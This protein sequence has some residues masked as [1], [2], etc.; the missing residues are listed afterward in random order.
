MGDVLLALLLDELVGDVRE[1]L[2]NLKLLERVV[3]FQP[4][5]LVIV[6]VPVGC[7]CSHGDGNRNP[8][9]SA[10]NSASE[11]TYQ[12]SLQADTDSSTV[13]KQFP[14]ESNS[15][16]GASSTD[17]VQKHTCKLHRQSNEDESGK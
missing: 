10:Q 8:I 3:V 7:T 4:G 11:A 17:K 15:M 12:R 13:I 1:V 16:C 9:T 2:V 6:I 5:V 14:F